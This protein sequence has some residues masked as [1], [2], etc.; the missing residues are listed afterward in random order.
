MAVGLL[1]SASAPQNLNALSFAQA[2]TRLMPNGTAPCLVLLPCSRMKL[3]ATS[4][5]AISPRR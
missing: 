3:P 5:M 4:S 1:S 2:I